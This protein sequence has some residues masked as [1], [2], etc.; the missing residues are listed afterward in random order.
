MA[1]SNNKYF[2]QKCPTNRNPPRSPKAP[3]D[4]QSVTTLA[5]SNIGAKHPEIHFCRET[6]AKIEIDDRLKEMNFGDW[7]G[8]HWDSILEEEQEVA[9]FFEYFIDQPAPRGESLR[10]LSRRVAEL[11]DELYTSG[12]QRV[13]LFSHGGVVNVVRAMA[14]RITLQEAFAQILPYGSVTTIDL[15]ELIH[16]D[17]IKL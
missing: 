3:F 6:W 4:T 14:G 17:Q 10:D 5:S 7:E 8:K 15:D 16:I 12:A 11:L 2:T 9:A 1:Q 13:L